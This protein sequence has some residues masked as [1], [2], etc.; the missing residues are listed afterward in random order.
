MPLIRAIGESSVDWDSLLKFGLC[1]FSECRAN[2]GLLDGVIL[3]FCNKNR[4]LINFTPMEIDET[5]EFE[6]CIL[7][8]EFIENKLDREVK[9]QI[10][11]RKITDIL[12]IVTNYKN[13]VLTVGI[14]LVGRNNYVDII[15]GGA[16][17]SISVFG[18][19][20]PELDNQPAFPASEYSYQPWSQN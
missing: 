8:F 2:H 7:T 19:D 14:R 17:F 4:L 5:D 12:R 1:G 18:W 20:F 3:E 6:E 13:N 16:L 9:R 11:D 10:F 15:G